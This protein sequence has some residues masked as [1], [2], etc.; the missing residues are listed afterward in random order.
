MEIFH[1]GLIQTLIQ[2]ALPGKILRKSFSRFIDTQTVYQHGFTDICIDHQDFFSG[3]C[4]GTGS[5]VHQDRLSFIRNTAGKSNHFYIIAAELNV[6]TQR[7]ITLAALEIQGAQFS[8]IQFLHLFFL[9]LSKN[10]FF[11][12]LLL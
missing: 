8:K 4:H 12:F 6:R 2:A 9:L 11:L 1:I 5:T 7:F 10:H 3:L